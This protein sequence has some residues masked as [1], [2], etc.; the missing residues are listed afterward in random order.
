MGAHRAEDP[1]SA[2]AA[3]PMAKGGAVLQEAKV[4]QAGEAH[5]LHL[6][7]VPVV[8]EALRL[9]Q[10]RHAAQLKVQ[11]VQ[12]AWRGHHQPPSICSYSSR[13]LIDMYR[14]QHTAP[15][16]WRCPGRFQHLHRVFEADGHGFLRQHVASSRDGLEHRILALVSGSAHA[17]QVHGIAGHQLVHRIERMWDAVFLRYRLRARQRARVNGGDL[18]TN[19]AELGDLYPAEKE[20]NRRRFCG[21]QPKILDVRDLERCVRALK[22]PTHL[23]IDAPARPD[24]PD[25][26]RHTESAADTDQCQEQPAHPSRKRG[27]R[28]QKAPASAD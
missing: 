13:A 23:H 27:F 10:R 22:F 3:V 15:V 17:H 16:R 1:A 28:S 6:A 9:S 18:Q 25:A 20:E 4:G 26:N 7:D 5:E 14:F 11:Q 2:L 12:S 24:D 8:N 19:T 21:D